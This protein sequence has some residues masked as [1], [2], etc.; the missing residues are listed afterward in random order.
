MA[1]CVHLENRRT[2]LYL[3]PSVRPLSCFENIKINLLRSG[4]VRSAETGAR[5]KY[6]SWSQTTC[7][8][9]MVTEVVELNLLVPFSSEIRVRGIVSDS[10]LTGSLRYAWIEHLEYLLS[11]SYLSI[12]ICLVDVL[13]VWCFRKYFPTLNTCLA[14]SLGGK[15]SFLPTA[16][17][18]GSPTG[19]C[20]K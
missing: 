8:F 11:Y 9:E 17:L 3:L 5:D 2:R 6:S 13:F 19:V 18:D 12:L 4:G 20:V 1:R 16:S 15:W 14:R 10:F 7:K